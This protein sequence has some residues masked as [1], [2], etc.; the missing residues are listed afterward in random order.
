LQPPKK[1]IVVDT[2]KTHIEVINMYITYRVATTRT[3]SL[4]GSAK[5]SPLKGEG[6]QK[7]KKKKKKK[8]NCQMT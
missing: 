7:K 8:K 1:K 5:I 4:A 6:T 3:A 2:M